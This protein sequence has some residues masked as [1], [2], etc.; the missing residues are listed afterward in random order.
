[1]EA[2]RPTEIVKWN[3]PHRF[4]DLQLRGP[5][6]LGRHEHR[7][8]LGLLADSRILRSNLTLN[9]RNNAVLA[10]FLLTVHIE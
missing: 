10:A 2:R 3:P 6:K 9:R 8:E 1:M 7:F 5:Y 4:V